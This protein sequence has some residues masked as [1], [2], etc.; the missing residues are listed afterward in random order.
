M[1]TYHQILLCLQK[2]LVVCLACMHAAEDIFK[3]LGRGCEYMN[4]ICLRLDSGSIAGFTNV[5]FLVG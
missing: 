5:I 2:R 1:Y 3:T 4:W